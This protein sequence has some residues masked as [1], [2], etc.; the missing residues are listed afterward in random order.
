MIFLDTETTGLI[1]PGVEDPGAQPRI[2]EIA[3]IRTIGYEYAPIEEYTQLLNPGVALDPKITQI[4]G[5]RDED[6]KAAP[7]F[8]AVI[9]DLIRVFRADEENTLIAHNLPFDLGMLVFELRRRG[10]EQRFPYAW[11]QVDTV[12]MSG[13]QKLENWAKSLGVL[14]DAQSHRALDDARLLWSCYREFQHRNLEEE[15]HASPAVV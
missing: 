7:P 8:E 4:T 13:G 10:W 9:Q 12:T 5:L 11:N 15:E 1:I 14:R 2:I 3:A 6:L